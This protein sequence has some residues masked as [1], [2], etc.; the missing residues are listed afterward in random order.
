MY[1][2]NCFSSPIAVLSS[3]RVKTM[4]S[5]HILRGGSMASRLTTVSCHWEPP[6]LKFSD[7]L[8]TLLLLPWFSVANERC[9]QWWGYMAHYLSLPLLNIISHAQESSASCFL[10]VV[11]HRS[12]RRIHL[13]PRWES[14]ALIT[15]KAISSIGH[16][17]N[18][19]FCF[20]LGLMS[21]I[22]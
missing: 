17:H 11:H 3:L 15:C 19:A 18:L 4:Q 1:F 22:W 8:R 2:C 6:L 7:L 13:C 21:F 9:H 10:M 5:G 14:L 20:D 16:F 12:P